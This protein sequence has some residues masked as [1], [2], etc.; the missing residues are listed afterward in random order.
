LVAHLFWEQEVVGS[1]PV[2]LNFD[3]MKRIFKTEIDAKF[4]LLRSVIV[5]I[6]WGEE[7]DSIAAIKT[8][9]WVVF[10]FFEN[11]LPMEKKS[12]SPLFCAYLMCYRSSPT[13]N[14]KCA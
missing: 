10:N 8:G 7:G 3:F 13:V 5:K 4:T 9:F 2:T 6:L 12:F 14:L 1:N 11:S